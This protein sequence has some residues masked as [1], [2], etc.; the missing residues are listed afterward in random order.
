MALRVIGTDE[1][2]GGHRDVGGLD[3]MPSLR[4]RLAVGAAVLG[5][6]LGVPPRRLRTVSSTSDNIV[7]WRSIEATKDLLT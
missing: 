4:P 6:V 7:L 3:G 1:A 5:P 2:M